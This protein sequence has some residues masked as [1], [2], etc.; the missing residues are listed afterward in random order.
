MSTRI[1][2]ARG[3][4]HLGAQVLAAIESNSVAKGDV[5]TVAKVAAIQAAKITGTHLIPLCHPIPL[6]QVSVHFTIDHQSQEVIIESTVVAT[7]K[8]GVEMEALTAV[9]VAALTIYDMVKAL[10][11]RVTIREVALVAK[12]GGKSDFSEDDEQVSTTK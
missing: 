1:A 5:F 10:N 11:K 3:R 12:S 2:R 4:V 7:Y 6:D 8:T 9:T